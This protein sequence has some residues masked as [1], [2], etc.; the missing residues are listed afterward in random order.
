MGRQFHPVADLLPLLTAEAFWDLAADINK[1]GLRAP[2]LLDD[3]CGP[4][5][6]WIENEAA[7]RQRQGRRDLGADLRQGWPNW[8]TTDLGANLHQGQASDLAK[9]R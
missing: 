9:R 8:P 7:E 4:N 3:G 2:V 1:N 5:G 6:Q